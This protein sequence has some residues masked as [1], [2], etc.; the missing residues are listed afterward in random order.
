[1]DDSSISGTLSDSSGWGPPHIELNEV[2]ACP[3]AYYQWHVPCFLR[4]C[5]H[6][7]VGN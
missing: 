7:D 5:L 6:A 4:A 1:M 3:M 2:I